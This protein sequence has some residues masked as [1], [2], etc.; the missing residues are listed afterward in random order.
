[1][2]DYDRFDSVS[3][4]E[5]QT[6]VSDGEMTT[7]NIDLLL[8]CHS[9]G[10]NKVETEIHIKHEQKILEI[11]S[12]FSPDELKRLFNDP[13]VKYPYRE[14][15]NGKTG[16]MSALLIDSKFMTYDYL[17]KKDIKINYDADLY[18]LVGKLFLSNVD[19]D[20]Y[21]IPRE[22]FDAF[23][24]IIN[25]IRQINPLHNLFN[26]E[27]W[28]SFQDNLDSLI[29][30]FGDKEWWNRD[31]KNIYN[32]MFSQ[33]QIKPWDDQT[34]FTEWE[35][36]PKFNVYSDLKYTPQNFLAIKSIFINS[37]NSNSNSNSNFNSNLMMGG[38]KQK[39][40]KYK[41][42]YIELKQSLL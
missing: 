28:S 41:Q 7:R 18:I 31:V 29:S 40:L 20:N 33:L 34:L 10:R 21:G 27:W 26:P 36:T 2:C 19:S 5:L 9:D 4:Y 22:E 39:Y 12:K 8:Y 17:L 25:H 30:R 38:Y 15:L 42:K 6:I 23:L 14:Y 11:L 35:S 13:R 1:M 37:S 32:R 3:A 24:N 16:T